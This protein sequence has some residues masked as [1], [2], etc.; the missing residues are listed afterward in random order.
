[1]SALFILNP[2]HLISQLKFIEDDEN[3]M[4]IK[5]EKIKLL[6]ARKF[7]VFFKMQI[8]WVSIP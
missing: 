3:N 7:R 2:S 6:F 8:L 4:N 1:M 5:I